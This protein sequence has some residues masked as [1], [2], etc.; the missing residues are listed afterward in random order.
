MD[1]VLLVVTAL[2][3]SRLVPSVRARLLRG[4]VGAYLAL[5]LC[6]GAG[7]IANDF[8]LEQV[9]KRGWASWAVPSVLEP[10]LKWAWL[11]LV[12]AAAAL[13]AA[14]LSLQRSPAAGRTRRPSRA[15]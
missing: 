1:G 9:V 2:F 11:V 13:W 8:W 6:Y 12:L 5:L 7:N 10:R 14:W 3:L 15:P 4:L